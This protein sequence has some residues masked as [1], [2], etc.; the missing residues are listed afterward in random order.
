M[1]FIIIL[2]VLLVL[3]LIRFFSI[4]KIL[5]NGN[6]ILID[7]TIKSGKSLL[8]IWLAIWKVRLY[9][10]FHLKKKIYIYSNIPLRTKYIPITLEMIERKVNILPKSIVIF[11]EASLIADSMLYNDKL[12]NEQIQLFVKLF[13]H[14]SK[15]GTLI[16]NTQNYK[17]L[18]FDIKRC[19]SN[20][21]AI[22]KSS[23]TLFFHKLE[24]K[25]VTIIEDNSQ[26]S[27]E[28]IKVY[29]PKFIYKY[30]DR[31]CFSILTDSNVIY[32]KVIDNRKSKNLKQ[33]NII[34]FRKFRTINNDTS[35]KV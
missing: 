35:K 31:Y 17:D 32:D 1:L 3:Y 27:E 9:N 34:T 15:G 5:K 21:Y 10:L 22:V 25:E 23:K 16:Y 18:H 7:G 13:A 19:V 12:I 29:V 2:L 8:T 24:L 6:F 14:W 26:I 28:S 4:L 20:Y 30:Y 33:G 11:D